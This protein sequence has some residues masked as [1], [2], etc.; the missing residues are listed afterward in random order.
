MEIGVW[1]G[2]GNDIG[3]PIPIAEARHHIAG[4]CLLNDWSARDIQSWESAPLGPFL[5]KLF[6]LPFSM[7]HHRRSHGAV[8]HHAATAS[9]WRPSTAAAS[10]ECG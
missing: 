10:A 7:D 6:D 8:P 5:E 9:R 4:F 1:I 2:P 3:S